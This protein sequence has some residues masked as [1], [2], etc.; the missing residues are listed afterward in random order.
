MS[1]KRNAS[2]SGDG[3]A[4]ELPYPDSDWLPSLQRTIQRKLENGDIDEVDADAFHGMMGQIVP[5]KED[6]K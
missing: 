6:E 2:R 3:A 5:E 1:S 4:N